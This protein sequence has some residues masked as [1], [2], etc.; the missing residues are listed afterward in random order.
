MVF[1]AT[2]VVLWLLGRKV[3][4]NGTGTL[5]KQKLLGYFL[6]L[7]GTVFVVTPIQEALN[8]HNYLGIAYTCASIILTLVFL[9][10]AVV[11]L[12]LGRQVLGKEA[13]VSVKQKLLGYFLVL[14]GAGWFL[15]AILNVMPSGG[16]WETVDFGYNII[17]YPVFLATAVVLVFLGRKNL[18]NQTST[19]AR[20]A[21]QKNSLF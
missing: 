11:L 17:A 7:W 4:G 8:S 19:S 3:L 12:L 15:N 14:W 10:M 18:G 21:D 6:V 16:Y 1:F 20:E 9:A 5:T 13:G 2:A